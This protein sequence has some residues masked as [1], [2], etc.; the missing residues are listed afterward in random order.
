MSKEE[1]K[2]HD[3]EIR[4]KISNE[5]INELFKDEEMLLAFNEGV[6]IYT[7]EENAKMH[8]TNM[9]TKRGYYRFYFSDD[10]EECINKCKDINIY[11]NSLKVELEKPRTPKEVFIE[12]GEII[13]AGTRNF[14]VILTSL[15]KDL[16]ELKEIYLHYPNF[17]VGSLFYKY[18]KENVFDDY[19]RIKFYLSY[20]EKEDVA[21]EK[22]WYTVNHILLRLLDLVVEY[23]IL[24]A[25]TLLKS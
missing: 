13:K 19:N 11:L 6:R 3:P 9:K 17:K 7:P 1:V 25:S 24:A 20:I 18:V 8:E 22:I 4:K 10:N 2:I 15:E 14:T 16:A 21:T 5:D 23:R 12:T